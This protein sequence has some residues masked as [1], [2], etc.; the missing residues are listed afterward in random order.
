[1]YI[2]GASTWRHIH[3]NNTVDERDLWDHTWWDTLN[4]I[5]LLDGHEVSELFKEWKSL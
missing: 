2:N 5:G 3:T 1:M 4:E